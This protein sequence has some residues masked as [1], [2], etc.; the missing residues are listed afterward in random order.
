[1]KKVLLIAV[2]LYSIVAYAQNVLV[3]IDNVSIGKYNTG[4]KNNEFVNQV[5]Y[6][7]WSSATITAVIDFDNWVI[8]MTNK[9]RSVYKLGEHIPSLS[10]ESD[11][12]NIHIITAC[13]DAVDEES[14]KC[15]IKVRSLS[16]NIVQI[17]AYYT[18]VVFV[19]QGKKRVVESKS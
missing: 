11:E 9:S 14:I 7:D 13:W 10:G 15:I 12:G 19:W 16:N 5:D 17:Y 4:Y 6:D 3:D 1:M 2:L 8:K 18:D